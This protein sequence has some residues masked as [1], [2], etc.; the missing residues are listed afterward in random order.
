MKEEFNLK[1]EREKWFNKWLQKKLTGRA[2]IELKNQD[3][4]FIELLKENINNYW[5][6][7]EGQ[8]ICPECWEHRKGTKEDYKRTKECMFLKIFKEIDKLSGDK[9]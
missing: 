7:G 3:K 9:A 4:E 1:S 6:N 8:C 2:I 5:T